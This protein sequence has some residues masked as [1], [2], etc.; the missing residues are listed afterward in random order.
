M[1]DSLGYTDRTFI[2]QIFMFKSICINHTKN[3]IAKKKRSC[4]DRFF[5]INL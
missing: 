5:C 3:H 4:S 2:R 1:V